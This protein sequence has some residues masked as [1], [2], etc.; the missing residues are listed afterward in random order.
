MEK[1]MD[2]KLIG[3][4]AIFFLLFGFFAVSIFLDSAPVPIRATKS[5][6]PDS[7]QSIL[8]V[9][10]L[11]QKIGESVTVNCVAR[12]SEGGAI[13]NA[14]CTVTTS[15][16]SISPST[17]QTNANGIA[18]FTLTSDAP[19]VANLSA[20]IGDVMVQR[21]ISVEFTP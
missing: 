2:P 14:G 7:T 8:L 19:C 13:A 6:P 3:L 4:V 21:K 17:T 20:T 10:P 16:G 15:C 18:T 11:S 12:D 1:K 5:Q 9:F